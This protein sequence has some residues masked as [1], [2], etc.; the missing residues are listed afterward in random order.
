MPRPTESVSILANRP[1][2]TLDEWCHLLELRK[3]ALGA[4]LDKFTLP[5]LRGVSCLYREG[6][7][8]TLGWSRGVCSAS[9][10]SLE[11]KGI[12]GFNYKSR[13]RE[14]G[15]L[16]IWG[17]TRKKQWVSVI[18][19]FHEESGY[20]GR[21]LEVTDYVRIEE[22]SLRAMIRLSESHPKDIYV[23]LSKVFR[24]YLE[25]RRSQY[26]YLKEVEECFNTEDLLVSL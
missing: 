22:V 5:E 12:F 8:G 15:R 13:Q 14:D 3:E 1:P 25:M 2:L 26:Q 17:L 20:K 4:H 10:M 9:G 16:S 6:H 7:L 19:Y 11:T 18:V 23:R 21:G 24:D